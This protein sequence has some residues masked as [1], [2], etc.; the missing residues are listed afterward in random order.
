VQ[1]FSQNSEGKRPV[2]R[3]CHRWEDN[4]KMN[5]RGTECRYVDWICVVQARSS[6]GVLQ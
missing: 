2:G 1:N 3:S 4:I 5:L 6:G